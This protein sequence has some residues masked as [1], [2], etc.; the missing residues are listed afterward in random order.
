MEVGAKVYQGRIVV[1]DGEADEKI[2]IKAGKNVELKI[3]D[4]DC[5]PFKVYE[6][7]SKD[8]I[9]CEC[10][11][12]ESKRLADYIKDHVLG[13]N[14]L[15]LKSMNELNKLMEILENEIDYYDK[16]IVVPLD[17][18]IGY[19]QDC[20]IKSTG[21]IIISGKGE[22]TSNLNAMRDIMFTQSNSV[23]RGGSL[24]AGGS[25]SAGII[26]SIAAISTVLTV[27]LS[28]KISA[29]YAYKN[30]TFCF[31]KKRLTIERDMEN[32]NVFYDSSIHDIHIVSSSL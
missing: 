32:I 23:A 20:E 15:N 8:K 16:N 17:V 7:T 24:T 27:P 10:T 28:G 19:C 6:V 25:I 9:E 2:T 1:N 11:K 30:T 29:T 5:E 13:Y 22:Y 21:N 18:R 14:I 26:G 12:T 31:G 4:T 3:N